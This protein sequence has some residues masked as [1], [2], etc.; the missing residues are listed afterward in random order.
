M[1]RNMRFLIPIILIAAMTGIAAATADREELLATWNSVDHQIDVSAWDF[2]LKNGGTPTPYWYQIRYYP[3][4]Q[5]LSDKTSGYITINRPFE[6]D[7]TIY[8]EDHPYEEHFSNPPISGDWMVVLMKGGTGNAPNEVYSFRVNVLVNVPLPDTKS[9]VLLKTANPTEYYEDDVD[10]PIIYTYTIWNNGNVPLS[11]PFIVV[12]DSLGTIDPCGTTGSLDPGNTK[13]CTLSHTI[14]QGDID[15]EFGITNT[16]TATSSN[17]GVQSTDDAFVPYM[18]SRPVPP[19]IPEFPTVA[20]P[21]AAVIGIMF[22]MQRRNK[23][24]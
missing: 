20:L 23:E 5:Y 7:T 16:A 2:K 9:I 14:T 12:D 6:G 18:G 24:K 22:F 17:D 21:V 10:K 11:G 4:P 13:T 19:G 1:A 8:T 3:L 15:N